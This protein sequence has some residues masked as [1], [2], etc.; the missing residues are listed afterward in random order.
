[1][2]LPSNLRGRDHSRQ[3][4]AGEET[5]LLQPT[6]LTGNSGIFRQVYLGSPLPCVDELTVDEVKIY[7]VVGPMEAREVYVQQLPTP[8]L[9][10]WAEAH[11]QREVGIGTIL[12][13]AD[14]PVTLSDES[15]GADMVAWSRRCQASMGLI[16][17]CLDE[18]LAGQLLV[19][20][21]IVL[22]ES[23]EVVGVADH[24]VG[25][26]NYGVDRTWSIDYQQALE[27]LEPSEAAR[28]ACRWF[29]RGVANGPSETG[30]LNLATCIES[31]VNDPNAGKPAFHVAAIREMYEAAGGS[32]G[33]LPLSIG[34]CAGLR[35]EIVHK[36]TEDHDRLRA[37]WYSLE[38]VARLLL[39]SKL[40]YNS[41]W[42]IDPS[43][44]VDALLD[45][46][47]TDRHFQDGLE[48]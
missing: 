1:M 23:G 45:E 32:D 31:L 40:E 43:E 20:N 21:L 38:R 24:V 30:I 14:L 3:E 4:T 19:E 26:R 9:L 28:S 29:L 8:G 15:L 22:D 12:I 35:A 34:L 10:T 47:V 7:S 39:R 42:P 13:V 16:A 48:V 25:I 6:G 2:R 44:G 27:G 17:A 37:G 11:H 41:P 46:V 36:G 33:E 18:R 5:H